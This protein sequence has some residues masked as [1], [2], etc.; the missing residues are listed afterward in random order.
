MLN[1]LTLQNYPP[2]DNKT[3]FTFKPLT[4]LSGKNGSGKSSLLR[5]LS[6]MKGAYDEGRYNHLLKKDAYSMEFTFKGVEF[7]F[8]ADFITYYIALCPA[9]EPFEFNLKYLSYQR[10]NNFYSEYWNTQEFLLNCPTSR[11]SKIKELIP[12]SSKLSPAYQSLY[13]ILSALANPGIILIELPELYLHPT[14]QSLLGRLLAESASPDRQ[15]ILETHSDHILTGIRLA[16]KDRAIQAEDVQLY[17]F[18]RYLCKGKPKFEM[19]CP[20]L[21]QDGGID[22]WPEGFFD[23]NNHDLIQLL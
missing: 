12:M 4:L 15:I 20:K 13:T 14:T 11:D 22:K 23:Q 17:H 3:T 18:D 8:K 10:I 9:N 1:S 7:I 21:Y 16:V 19:K 2:W 6:G 5:V